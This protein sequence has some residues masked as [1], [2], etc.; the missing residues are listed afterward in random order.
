M[1]DIAIKLVHFQKNDFADNR[2]QKEQCFFDSKQKMILMNAFYL[3]IYIIYTVNVFAQS[4]RS[5]LPPKAA[6]VDPCLQTPNMT[7]CS[8]VTTMWKSIKNNELAPFPNVSTCCGINGVE[9]TADN[10]YVTKIV[11]RMNGVSGGLTCHITVLSKLEHLE[12]SNNWD[13][14]SLPV[15]IGNVKSLKT[16]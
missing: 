1:Q 9:C 3:L 15:N 13:F 11:W 4:G 12:I 7:D 5:P 6:A 2:F 16:L 10:R 8:A 14:S